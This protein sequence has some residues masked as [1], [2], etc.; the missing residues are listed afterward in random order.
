VA[1]RRGP[2]ARDQPGGDL[3][4]GKQRRERQAAAPVILSVLYSCA[5][6]SGLLLHI[7]NL[8]RMSRPTTLQM[9]LGGSE[10]Q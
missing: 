9:R 5:E 2:L 8:G 3:P 4:G 7:G 6:D 10:C 1:Q